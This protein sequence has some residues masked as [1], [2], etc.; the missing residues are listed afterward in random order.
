MKKKLLVTLTLAFVTTFIS[1][2]KNDGENSTPTIVGKWR[3]E[4]FD[5]YINGQLNETVIK[6]EDNLNCSDYVEFKSNN[7]Y[8]SIENNANCNSTVDESG[9]YIYD[10]TNLTTNSNGSSET[11]TV[12]SLTS[13]DLKYD[14]TET[15]SGGITYKTV[16]YL[17]KIN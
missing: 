11:L 7:T 10:G 15:S 17:K 9:T 6:V 14:L 1:C 3:A 2:S 5:Y 13:S 16:G 8:L 4:K 12:M